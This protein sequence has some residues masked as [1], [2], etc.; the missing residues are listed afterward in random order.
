MPGEP[1]TLPRFRVARNPAK[2]QWELLDARS[3]GAV[4]IEGDGMSYHKLVALRGH[5][6][7]KEVE[8]RSR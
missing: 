8:A 3:G 4:A 7:Q 2:L 6:N 1:E 5:L